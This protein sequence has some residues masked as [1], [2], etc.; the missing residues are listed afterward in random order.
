MAAQ[1][2]YILYHNSTGFKGIVNPNRYYLLHLQVIPNQYDFLCSGKKIFL[3]NVGVVFVH[4]MKVNG[5][6]C[7]VFDSTDFH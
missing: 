1:C 7:C 2:A 6:R 3:K 5:V 4:T